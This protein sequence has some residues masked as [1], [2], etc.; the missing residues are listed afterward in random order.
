[1]AGPQQRPVGGACSREP[2][3]RCPERKPSSLFDALAEAVGRTDG[4]EPSVDGGGPTSSS[5]AARQLRILVAEDNLVNQK[6]ALRVLDKLG[7]R[8]EVAGNGLEALHAVE[9]QPYDVVLMDVQM[10]EMD[11][12]QA[13]RRIRSDLP[14]SKQPHIIATTANAFAEDRAQCLAAGMDDY[15]SKPVRRDDLAAALLRVSGQGTA[16]ATARAGTPRERPK[17]DDYRGPASHR[18][19]ERGDRAGPQRT[20]TGP[21][22]SRRRDRA[23]RSPAS[24]QP[25]LGQDDH[26]RGEAE[27]AGE[28]GVGEP[29]PGAG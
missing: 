11:G 8:A 17:H 2:V 24:G 1:M 25:A 29:D 23:H 14:P 7:Y 16:G 6:V 5:A 12:L 28:L 10:P 15:L 9:R 20:T 22:M 19:S 26:Q 27:R 4:G 18:R 3:G 21:P 13:T